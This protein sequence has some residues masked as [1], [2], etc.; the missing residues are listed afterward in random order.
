MAD[1]TN[2]QLYERIIICEPED[3]FDMMGVLAGAASFEL[4]INSRLPSDP[5][6]QEQASNINRLG[7]ASTVISPRNY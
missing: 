6:K 1:K 7:L 4:E 3:T 2:P 5:Q